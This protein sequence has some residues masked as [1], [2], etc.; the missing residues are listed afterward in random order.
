MLVT[1]VFEYIYLLL[2]VEIKYFV[3]VDD[4]GDGGVVNL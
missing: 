4:D 3:V 2:F 1:L